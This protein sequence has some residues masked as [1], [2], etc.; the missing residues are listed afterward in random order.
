[1]IYAR[2]GAGLLLALVLWGGYQYLWAQ[3]RQQLAEATQALDAA[4]AALQAAEVR[5]AEAAVA[6]GQFREQASACSA[7]LDA[8]AGQ[9]GT[10][11]DAADAAAVRELEALKRRQADILR[12]KDRGPARMNEAFRELML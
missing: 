9:C 4:N 1:M 2:I 8:L 11:A 10:T 7:Q 6:C 12:R 5:T 3:P